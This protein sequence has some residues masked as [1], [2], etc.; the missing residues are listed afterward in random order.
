MAREMVRLKVNVIVTSGTSAALAAKRAT[1]TIPVVMATGT[2]QVSLG[3]AASLARP[4]G[5]ITGLSTLTS[6]LMAKRVRIGAHELHS[7]CEAG[8]RT[9]A[10][11]ECILDGFGQ[12]PRVRGLKIEGRT[13]D[14]RS[15][16][17]RGIGRSFSSMAR[18][19]VE[20]VI[21]VQT[22]LMYTERSKIADLADGRSFTLKPGMSYQVADNAEPHRSH[23]ERGAK[24][25][26]VD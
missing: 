21:V 24:L 15:R 1:T 26:I 19:R 23:T 5:N 4:G 17:R 22:P 6:E 8:G 16:R 13:S 7:E 25:F 11:R 18:E 20:A 3:L 9:L 14:R 10:Q 2:D 12:R